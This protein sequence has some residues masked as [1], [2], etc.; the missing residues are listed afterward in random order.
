M[1][2]ACVVQE[3]RRARV[4]GALV[5]ARRVG[6]RA[7]EGDGGAGQ[8]GGERGVRGGRR[9]RRRRHRRP[10][11]AQVLTVSPTPS[12][13]QSSGRRNRFVFKAGQPLRRR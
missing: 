12:V 7:A 8:R 13:I 2:A 10:R 11:H 4:E 1:S 3:F 6:A 9:R 5:D